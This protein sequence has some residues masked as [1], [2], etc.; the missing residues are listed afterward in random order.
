ML[1]VSRTPIREALERLRQEG[2][3]T[4][5]P[6]H[7]FF[8]SEID[9][10]QARN[11]YQT[12]EALEV[13]ALGIAI[14]KGISAHDM[15]RLERAQQLYAK[16]WGNQ[17]LLERQEVDRDLHLHLASLSGNDYL[18][19]SLKEIFDRLLLK[20]RT[21]GY[22]SSERHLASTGEHEKLL[23]ALRSGNK[24]DAQTIL[25]SHLRGAWMAFEQHLN[26][27]R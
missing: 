17:G 15:A 1:D 22:F 2:Y 4:H 8:V 7:G 11:L 18:V 10:A 25:A 24:R 6:R 26:N 14:D 20:R 3:V 27:F 19:R 9:T 16:S 13:Y 23:E 21:D 12:R 5:K